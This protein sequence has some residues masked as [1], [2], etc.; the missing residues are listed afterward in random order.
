MLW[1]SSPSLAI[2]GLGTTLFETSPSPIA[3][4]A[5][6]RRAS[7]RS[8]SARSAS[9]SA[10]VSRPLSPRS[11]AR[12][13]ISGMAASMQVTCRP[14]IT[15]MRCPV[16]KQR[17][18]D[19]A[20]G[21]KKVQPDRRR[22]AGD[23]VDAGFAFVGDAAARREHGHVDARAG[24][25]VV[26]AHGGLAVLRGNEP[27]LDGERRHARQHVAAVGPR[28]DRLLADSDLREQVVD[29]AAGLRRARDDRHLA[30]ERAAAAHAVDLQQVG[31]TDGADQ[32]LVAPA[33]SAG[34]HSRR[35]NGPR[36]VPAR[37]RTQGITRFMAE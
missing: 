17:A 35:K 24:V 21:V 37:I 32:R 28:V 11:P 6:H 34:S 2:T 3:S 26:H 19:G 9:S 31:R 29:V 10:G 12:T 15:S 25:D 33:S 16:G 7:M 4:P 1:S 30:G 27:L 22:R 14:S 5:A 36:E 20:P 13:I 8:S 18:S 23:A